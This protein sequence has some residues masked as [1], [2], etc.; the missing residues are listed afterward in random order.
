MTHSFSYCE[1]HSDDPA[2]AKAFYTELFGWK[3]SDTPT[4]YGAY[5]E[6][7]TGEG[8]EAGL[9]KNMLKGSPAWIVYV[10]V[11]DV[12]AHTQRAQSLGAEILAEVGEVPGVGLFSIIR[13]PAGAAFGLFQRTIKK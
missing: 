13:D 4:P 12:R 1:L 2:R 7:Q 10:Q 6:I 9:L 11:D 8:L 5:T 3:S